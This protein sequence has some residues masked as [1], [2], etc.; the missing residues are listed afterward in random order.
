[1]STKTLA[2]LVL[3]LV[4][5]LGLAWSNP[6]A[7]D[8]EAFED[9]LLTEMIAQLGSGGKNAQSAVIRQLASKKNRSFFQSLV[10]SQTKRTNLGLFSLYETSLFKTKIWVIGIA[11]RFIPLTDMDQAVLELEQS[12]ISPSK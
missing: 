1:M 2:L 10:R 7:Q 11:G 8:Y 6:T 4:G 12:V 5:A 9:K 3:I